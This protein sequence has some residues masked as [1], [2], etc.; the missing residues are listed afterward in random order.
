MAWLDFL[1]DG[2]KKTRDSITQEI[3]NIL[4]GEKLTEERLDE[5][6]EQLI[7]A[8][9]GVE[10]AFLLVDTLR[11]RALGQSLSWEEI[12]TILGSAAIDLL[13]D[14]APVPLHSPVHVILI[15]GVNGAGKT[16]TIGKLSKRFTDEGRKVLVAAGDTF[17][18]AAIE[19]LETWTQR[20]GV[21]LVKHQENSDSAAVAHDAL[22]AAQN[23]GCDTLIID[24]AGRLHNK[25]HLM[26][27]LR[28]IQRV[29]QRIDPG[30]PNETLLVVDGTTGQNT[31][32]QTRTFHQDIQLT[33]LV[34][35]KLDGTAKGGAAISIAH[36]L[37]LPICW[38]GTGEKITDLEPFD[39]TQYVQGLFGE[40]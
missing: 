18:A 29:L 7:R 10:T 38:I 16:T 3:K 22:I 30:V 14:P 28:K 17:R 2:L 40:D 9:V 33:G 37:K 12:R 31:V 34:L 35:T 26:E 20:A 5:L 11:R 36:E 39:K 4:G 25:Q 24:T 1:R 21:E 23:R 27:E 8:D 6:E 13:P 19:Q 32:H 15:V